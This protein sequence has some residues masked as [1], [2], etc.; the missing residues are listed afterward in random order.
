MDPKDDIKPRLDKWL[1]AVRVF[2][3]RSMATDACKKGKIF[4]NG[5]AAKPSHLVKIGE[6]IERRESMITR[7]FKVTGLLE[8]RVSAKVAV[9]YMEE[10]TPP[11]EFT[12]LELARTSMIAVR[13]RGSGRPTKKERRDIEK[14]RE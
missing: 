1:W 10:V 13:E 14:L 3:T 6:V 2:K 5:I 7:S 8:K 9:N 4:I 12:K 11:E